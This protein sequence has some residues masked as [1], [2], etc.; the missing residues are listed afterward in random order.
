MSKWATKEQ[1]MIVK[2]SFSAFSDVILAEKACLTVG[3][4]RYI[5]RKF[6]LVK[7]KDRLH[8]AHRPQALA[9]NLKRWNKEKE[10]NDTN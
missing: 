3:Q 2:A 6:H 1:I 10:S 7:S 5:G 4:V 9:T 8:E